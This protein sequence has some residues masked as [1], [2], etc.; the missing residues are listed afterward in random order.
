MPLS[1]DVTL[2]VLSQWP[3]EKT[4][5]TVLVAVA[6]A[7]VGT[8]RTENSCEDKCSSTR[9]R[10][11]VTAAAAAAAAAADADAADVDECDEADNV[12]LPEP[13]A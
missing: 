8:S 10:R 3:H 9:S 5:F 2:N 1:S 12:V 13:L 11:C 7:D 6:V 4:N